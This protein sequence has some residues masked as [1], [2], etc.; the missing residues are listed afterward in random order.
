[1]KYFIYAGVIVVLKIK[2]KVKH[3]PTVINNPPPE[4][5]PQSST[6]LFVALIVI[7][8]LIVVVI[9]FIL[10]TFQGP[11]PAEP[12]SAPAPLVPDDGMDINVPEDIDVDIDRE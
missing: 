8:A 4:R 6:G 11:S 2:Y 1:M 10:P 3:M 7:I 5:E 12:N 9:F